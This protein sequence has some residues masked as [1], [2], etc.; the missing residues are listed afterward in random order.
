MLLEMTT[1]LRRKLIEKRQALGITVNE[2]AAELGVKPMTI[3]RWESGE[4]TH[5]IHALTPLVTD[6]LE[7]KYDERFPISGMPSAL[8]LEQEALKEQIRHL[9]HLYL[10]AREHPA[11]RHHILTGLHQ[12]ASGT[13]NSQ[14][15]GKP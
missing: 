5:C 1:E 8:S 2:V 14:A 15:P 13:Q 10:E 7:G 12:I 6:F 9:V 11:V 3:R 4:T